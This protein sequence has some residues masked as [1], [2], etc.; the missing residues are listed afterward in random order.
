MQTPTTPSDP[1][2]ASF[3]HNFSLL[4]SVPRLSK[5]ERAAST[6]LKTWAETL[7]LHPR[8]NDAWDLIFDV[9]ATPGL[10]TLPLLALQAH[11]DM[12]CVAREGRPYDPLRDPIHPILDHASGTLKADGTSL[13]ADDGAGVALIMSIAEGKMPHGPLRVLFTTDEE[14]G[15]TGAR[16]L[17]PEDLRGVKYLVNIDSETSDAMTVSSAADCE[18]HATAS[19]HPAA[20]SKT[21]AQ[22]I[23]LT[24]LSGGHS[25]MEIATGK[26]N[27]ILALA[28][29]LEQIAAHLPFELSTFTGGTAK[30]AIPAKARAVIVLAPSDLPKLQSILSARATEL[31]TSHVHTDPNLTLQTF[32][33]P[34]PAAVMPSSSAIRL[35]HY[36]T[37]TPNGVLAM[38]QTIDGLVETSSNLGLLEATPDHIFCLQMP[39]SSNPAALHEIITRQTALAQEC[40]F[41]LKTL[42]GSRAWPVNPHSALVPRLQQIYR[43]LT[44]PEMRIVAL[45]AGLECGLFADLSPHLDI[46]SIGPDITSP[47][48]PAETLHLPSIPLIWHLLEKLLGNIGNLPPE[49]PPIGVP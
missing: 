5:H 27:A 10:E 40:G 47:H 42:P 11:L 23:S 16:A 39:R 21:L 45:H 49:A 20:P 26:C 9:P 44:G 3:L 14:V 48:S 30:N 33:A 22:E 36:L 1:I 34:L 29:T 41:S 13:G 17:T 35:L 25:G 7:G 18:L 31:Q 28:E 12:V 19:L 32:P 6:L 46:L 24:N 8:Q 15:M 38:S 2:L 4:A 37:A 43:T